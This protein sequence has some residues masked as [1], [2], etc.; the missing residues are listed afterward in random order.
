MQSTACVAFP[1]TR[2]PNVRPFRFPT[3]APPFCRMGGV[4]AIVLRGITAGLPPDAARGGTKGIEPVYRR[5]R[6]V[7]RRQDRDV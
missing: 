3:P 6:G 1:P 7:G 4:R 2:F 5:F